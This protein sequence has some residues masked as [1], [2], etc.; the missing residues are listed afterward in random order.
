[1]KI[2]DSHI[3]LEDNI[4]QQTPV[5][6]SQYNLHI[7]GGNFIVNFLERYDLYLQHIINSRGKYSLTCIFDFREEKNIT[8][9]LNRVKLGHIQAAKIHSKIQHINEHEY[10]LLACQLTRVPN[11]VPI[12]LDGWY[13]WNNLSTQPSLA[14]N[15]RLALEHPDKKFIIA[16][17]GGA[18][19]LDYFLHTRKIDNI[20]YDLSLTLG[21]FKGCSVWKDVKHF[22]RYIPSTKILYG[23]DYP[24]Y[25]PVLQY[26]RLVKIM[27]K[28]GLEQSDI[29]NIMYNNSMQLFFNE[30]TVENTL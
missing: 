16:H 13:D 15:I 18:K 8:Q 25:D 2:F 5:D 4:F 26:K 29:D 22:V 6:M 17:A 1:M 23:S 7:H 27:H 9:F 11:N 3:H 14:Q 21:Y 12:I 19:I 24:Y 10:D 30:S 28:C 20:Y